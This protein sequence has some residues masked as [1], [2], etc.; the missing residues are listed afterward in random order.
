MKLQLTLLVT[1]IASAFAAEEPVA[2]TPEQLRK[3]L[4]KRGLQ[5]SD[6][7][8]SGGDD[9]GGSGCFSALNS[10]DVQGK[11]TISMDSLQIGDYVHDGKDYSRVF[12]FAHLDRDVEYD[13]VQIHTEGS[14]T[15]L[16]LTYNHMVFLA[17]KAVPAAD[18]TVGDML[19]ESKVTEI[20]NVKSTGLYA[21]ITYSGAIAVNG[22]KASSYVALM[23]N[24]PLD[25]HA[26]T[27]MFFGV[28]RAICTVNFSFCEGE[29]Y[30]AEGFSNTFN[31]AIQ[32]YMTVGSWGVAG[33]WAMSALC[34]IVLPMFAMVEQFVV[35]PLVSLVLVAYLVA[36]SKKTS[37]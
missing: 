29:T 11:G 3:G 14:K 12:G 10:V 31:W 35:A 25:Q 5:S 28:Q 34:A 17:N 32:T 8:D 30:S 20:K 4:K 33:Q 15:P 21:P 23:D 1:A 24:C 22:I 18:V 13:F 2:A 16:E 7:S 6:G 36:K 9:G 26:M 19:G 37:A 27:H